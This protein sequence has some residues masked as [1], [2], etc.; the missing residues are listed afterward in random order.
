[1]HESAYGEPHIA[2]EVV[3]ERIEAP[4]IARRFP[5]CGDVT[6]GLPRR[7]LG[8]ASTCSSMCD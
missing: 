6:E 1:V 5:Q 3:D 4:H 7:K 8:I 2:S